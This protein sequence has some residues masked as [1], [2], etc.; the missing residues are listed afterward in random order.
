MTKLK[1]IN[2]KDW[3]GDSDFV[4]RL[5]NPLPD[6]INEKAPLWVIEQISDSYVDN[7]M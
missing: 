6:E 7:I 5:Y 4:V 1:I 3:A 2:Q